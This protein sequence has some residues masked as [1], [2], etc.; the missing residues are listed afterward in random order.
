MIHNLVIQLIVFSSFFSAVSRTQGLVHTRPRL[1]PSCHHWCLMR[2]LTKL[3]LK[4]GL[5]WCGGV[6]VTTLMMFWV[7]LCAWRA[8]RIG[9]LGCSVLF[10]RAT[11]WK[12]NPEECKGSFKKWN[13]ELT[14]V[15][16][17]KTKS[18]VYIYKGWI[19]DI[20]IVNTCYNNTLIMAMAPP[21][22]SDAPFF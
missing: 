18:A 9:I 20:S 14:E 12:E 13:T 2:R 5:D 11:S 1:C 21:S 17:L 6:F 3:E 4:E 8:T 10:C 15:N 7:I 16:Y 19:A 22:F